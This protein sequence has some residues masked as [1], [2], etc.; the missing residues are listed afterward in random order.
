MSNA[1]LANGAGGA[2]DNE[3]GAIVGIARVDGNATRVAAQARGSASDQR[4]NRRSS[5]REHMSQD[6]GV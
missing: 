2:S 4:Q 5:E 1:V 3:H 6:F